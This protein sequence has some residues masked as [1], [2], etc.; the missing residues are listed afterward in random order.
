MTT[1]NQ[2]PVE[3]EVVDDGKFFFRLV[4]DDTGITELAFRKNAESVFGTILNALHFIN[5]S[6]EQ[7]FETL[8]DFIKV[9]GESADALDALQAQRMQEITD[10]QREAA[11]EIKQ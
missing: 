6:F 10:A 4:A 11:T 9:L 1:E 8:S 3:G 7:P 2:A 5:G